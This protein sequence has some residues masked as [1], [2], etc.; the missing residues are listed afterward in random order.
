MQ[1]EVKKIY[2]VEKPKQQLIFG[3]HREQDD[4]QNIHRCV[5][6]KKKKKQKK[7]K[8]KR[9]GNFHLVIRTNKVKNNRAEE[10]K[11]LTTETW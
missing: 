11:Q 3:T 6:W 9:N 4:M 10:M 1:V 2:F 7:G 5:W 8:L